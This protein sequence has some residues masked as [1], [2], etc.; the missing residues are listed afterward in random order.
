MLSSQAR[1]VI[2]GLFDPAY[3]GQFAVG[4]NPTSW[5]RFNQS[6]G[7]WTVQN[8]ANWNEMALQCSAGSGWN[9]ILYNVRT[10]SGAT[11]LKISYRGGGDR[12]TLAF[13]MA[14]LTL[15]GATMVS[16]YLWQYVPSTGSSTL[17]SAGWQGG[18]GAN[19]PINSATLVPANQNDVRLTVIQQGSSIVCTVDGTVV[20][21]VVDSTQNSGYLG[22]QEFS[23]TRY[24]GEVQVEDNAAGAVIQRR[25]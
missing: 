17:Y 1:A 10:F 20:H 21:N 23:N 9:A 6:G 3:W 18:V 24:A 22:F 16:G 7:D 5:N 4:T 13:D 25:R 2:L 11:Y 15:D 14:N 8:N 19:T 12:S